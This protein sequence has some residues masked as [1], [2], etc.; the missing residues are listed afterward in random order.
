MVMAVQPLTRMEPAKVWSP[1]PSANRRLGQRWRA[2]RR[3]GTAH[4]GKP[5]RSFFRLRYL[6]TDQSRTRF[7]RLGSGWKLRLRRNC[8]RRQ[9]GEPIGRTRDSMDGTASGRTE[10]AESPPSG[11]NRSSQSGDSA[12]AE[13]SSIA[14]AG[15]VARSQSG[16]SDSTGSTAEPKE[17]A[18]TGAEGNCVSHSG[19]SDSTGDTAGAEGSMIAGVGC[20][21][22][23]PIR[24]FKLRRAPEIG[25]LSQSGTSA[26]TAGVGAGEGGLSQSPESRLQ[27]GGVTGA[28]GLVALRGVE[29]LPSSSLTAPRASTGGMADCRWFGRCGWL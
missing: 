12:G 17:A 26:S 25:C 18:A 2:R 7:G 24:C 13:G 11:D 22:R 3:L 28:G 20:K 15:Q 16:D 14:A 8:Q 23:Q 10:P 6:F 19:T 9:L 5:C 1:T 27:D 29:G 4:V 21:S